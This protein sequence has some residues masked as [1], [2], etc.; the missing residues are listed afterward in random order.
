MHALLDAHAL[1]APDVVE[2]L[3][4]DA[5]S[6]LAAAE[7]TRRLAAGGR[8]ELASEPPVPAWRRFLAQF[9][10]VLVVLLLLS[11]IHI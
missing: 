10:D 8:N 7:A 2:R 1:S 6:G 5:R 3:A 4:T 9:K 11:L